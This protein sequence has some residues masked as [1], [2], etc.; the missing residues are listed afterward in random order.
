MFP[1]HNEADSGVDGAEI[2]WGLRNGVLDQL[3]RIV[4]AVVLVNVVRHGNRTRNQWR[5]KLS[6]DVSRATEIDQRCFSSKKVRRRA[7]LLWEI[8]CACSYGQSAMVN[9]S[10]KLFMRNGVPSEMS[11]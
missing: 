4:S 2:V 3:A 7:S 9:L 8:R 11:R 6:D 1:A 10:L 5:S